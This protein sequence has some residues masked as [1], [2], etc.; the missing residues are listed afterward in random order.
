MTF[1]VVL[2]P[3]AG[4]FWVIILLETVS[5]RI[6]T[7]K[8]WYSAASRISIYFV[9]FIIPVKMTINVAPFFD[10]PPHT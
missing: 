3:P 7:L 1:K 10:I 8:E 6:M 4:V 5:I 2:C 9:A